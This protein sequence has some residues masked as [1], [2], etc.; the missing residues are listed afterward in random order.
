MRLA[1][2]LAAKFREYADRLDSGNCNMTK[3]EMLDLFEAFTNSEHDD[4]LERHVD[5]MENAIST[6]HKRLKAVEDDK[7]NTEPTY[8]PYWYKTK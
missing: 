5:N 1:H 6:L 8:D 2:L 4:T 3:E 7:S